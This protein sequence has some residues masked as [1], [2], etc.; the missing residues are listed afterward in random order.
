MYDYSYTRSEGE[1]GKKRRKQIRNTCTITRTHIFKTKYIYIYKKHTY[2]C[3]YVCFRT[4]GAGK[5]RWVLKQVETASW[6]VRT[7][8]WG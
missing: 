5:G 1:R 2:N 3:S 8:G 6:E 4:W 7:C